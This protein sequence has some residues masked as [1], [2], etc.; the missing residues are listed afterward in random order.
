MASR[1]LQP[2]IQGTDIELA[3]TRRPFQEHEANPGLEVT[4]HS[5][6]EPASHQW[7]HPQP[8]AS[9]SPYT[10]LSPASLG[11]PKSWEKFHSESNAPTRPTT[12]YTLPITTPEYSAID[13]SSPFDQRPLVVPPEE[14]E[15][16]KRARICG[17]R[18]QLFWVLLAVGV[19]L[20]VAAVATG[21]GVGI[22]LSGSGGDR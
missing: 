11:L 14:G 12:P 7:H 22:G 19:F 16:G 4:G 9:P 5:T 13:F 8:F 21:V 10:G 18:R 1:P 3:P 20:V 6:L 2:D 17:M 15:A